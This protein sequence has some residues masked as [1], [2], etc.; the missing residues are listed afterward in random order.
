MSRR[1]AL[2]ASA[3]L[4]GA[5]QAL[6][7]RL[8][9]QLALAF[10]VMV[11]LFVALDRAS[12]RETIAVAIAYAL[13]LGEIAILPWLGPSLG[14]YFGLTGTRSQ[15][16]A[17]AVVALL[18]VLHGGALGVALALRPR[19]AHALLVLWYA[20]LWACWEALRSYVPPQ[21]PA[22][23]LGVS[24]E[25]SLPLLQ[26]ASATGVAGVTAVV[27]AANA[28]IAALVARDAP[29]GARW[30]AF[31][32]GAG[33]AVVATAW[34]AV[35]LAAT[36][37]SVPAAAR[38]VAV[39]LVAPDAAA[40]TLD[41]LIEATSAATAR[42]ARPDV[43]LWPES[44]LN[45]D[46]ARDRV[47]WA[48]IG[49]LVERAGATLVTGG[50]S[51]ELD[52]RGRP[53]RFNSLHVV[54]PGF[55]MQSYHK[56]LLVPLAESW[57]SFLGA[58]PASLEPVTAGSA[59]PVLDAG[60]TRFGPLICFE[61]ADA[62]SARALARD[63]ASFLVNVTND[64]WF[65]GTEAPHLR[66]A[67]IRAIESGLPVVRV[68]NAGTSVVF[69]PLGRA[70]VSSEPAARGEGVLTGTVP[71]AI[72]TVYVATGEV[73]L[74]ACATVVVLGVAASVVVV[75]RRRRALVAEAVVGDR[76]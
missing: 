75:L 29:R 24:L 34:G 17:A 62:A 54:R 57:P 28:G 21:F 25:R 33:V 47:A 19:R 20:A 41:V 2:V 49:E 31:A 27:V 67:R 55:G 58:P 9:G 23:A 12:T 6:L 60:E 70:V 3:V 68:A 15:L 36:T 16:L 11:P 4:S 56:R 48:R 46:L 26:V 59:L 10:V 44:A 50:V 71:P 39:D 76:T 69:D 45:L 22:A 14:P 30:R 37:A 74:P 73:F 66:W 40:S 63:G 65:Q 43:V 53:R 61:I 51:F 64:V 42:G 1:T 52:A 13:A 5:L 8:P 32:A 35:R 72:E 7:P 18:A 38:I